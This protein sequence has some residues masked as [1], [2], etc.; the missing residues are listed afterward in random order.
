MNGSESLQNQ[1]ADIWVAS[2]TD[3]STKSETCHYFVF[4]SKHVLKIHVQ[5]LLRSFLP[6]PPHHFFFQDSYVIY[7][8]SSFLF[9]FIS[10]CV[11]IS[12]RGV[13]PFLLSILFPSIHLLQVSKFFSSDLYLQVSLWRTK[14][15]GYD[16]ADSCVFSYLKYKLYHCPA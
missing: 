6:H 11:K 14:N 3:R 9:I 4:E 16:K 15:E 12:Q 10:E 8:A 2:G 13:T 7:L 5:Q 1:K